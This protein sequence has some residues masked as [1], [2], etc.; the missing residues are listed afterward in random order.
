[1]A[2]RC[3]DAVERL[4]PMLR[5]LLADRLLELGIDSKSRSGPLLRE[6]H[7]KRR[8]MSEQAQ[9][10]PRGLPA[11][12]GDCRVDVYTGSNLRL[13]RS[14]MH[15]SPAERL[16]IKSLVLGRHRD[17]AALHSKLKEKRLVLSQSTLDRFFSGKSR[18][19]RTLRTLACL[20][21]TTPEALV[22]QVK[23]LVRNT[24][25]PAVN[26]MLPLKQLRDPEAF[27]I[28]YQLWVEM[29]TRKLGLPIDP[30]QDLIS[31]CY[32]SWYAFF[33]AARELI[34]SIPLHKNP[35]SV[36]MRDLVW[37]SQAVLNDGLRPHL[38][39]WQARFR[40]WHAGTDDPE[41]RTCA[42]QET[43]QLF[44]DWA[45]LC[46]DLLSTNQRLIAYV[47]ALETMIAHPTNRQ[48]EGSID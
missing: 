25:A 1:M 33:K 36:E 48:I 24:G 21:G 10:N 20:L 32:D 27:R 16:R 15:L 19:P 45:E 14:R 46:A 12:R 38:Q 37:L 4:K 9:S 28:A 7:R 40:R 29:T 42:P 18:S 47:S 5:H 11:F 35:R 2:F 17:W 22:S 30:S 34:K 43:Q 41:N 26:G 23:I 44:P 6:I 39:R 31:E 8:S 3:A 13:P